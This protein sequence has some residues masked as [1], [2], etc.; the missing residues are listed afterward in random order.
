MTTP[1]RYG[2]RPQPPDHRDWSFSAPDYAVAYLAIA[3]VVDPL[4]ACLALGFPFVFG[5][6]VYAGFESAEVA[7]TGVLN[8]PAASEP[9]LG[10]HAVLAVGYDD[11]T[12][13][14][15]VRN[16]WGPS[17]G[18]KGYF[19]IPYAYLASVSLASDFWSI[20]RV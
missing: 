13:R 16:S 12:Q 9:C 18:D 7:K 6:K 4:R 2:W 19:T 20:R 5:F 1:R 3:Q 15:L 17:W 11:A 14:F 8:L 10:G